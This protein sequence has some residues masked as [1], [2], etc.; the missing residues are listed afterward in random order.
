P[1]EILKLRTVEDSVP[2]YYVFNGLLL[3]CHHDTVVT[4]NPLDIEF[5]TNHGYEI[6]CGVYSVY[7]HV[8]NDARRL[9]ENS[10]SMIL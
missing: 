10:L 3:K 2:M 7:I 9:L 1:S 6:E 5:G 4:E 8:N